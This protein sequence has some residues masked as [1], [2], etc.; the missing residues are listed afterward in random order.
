MTTIQRNY[1]SLIQK[2]KGQAIFSFSQFGTHW[3]NCDDKN[4]RTQ[5]FLIDFAA[6]NTKH[7]KA[8]K[9]QEAQWEQETDISIA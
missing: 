2:A 3:R 9:N 5:D 7:D 6:S 1:P 8:R 4:P